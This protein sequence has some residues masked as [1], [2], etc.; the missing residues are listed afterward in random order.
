MIKADTIARI[1]DLGLLAVLRG[2]SPEL[3][4]QM[5][6]ASIRGGV[7]GIEITYTTPHAA[8][9]VA[10][11]AQRYGDGI[12]LGMGTLTTPAQADEAAAAGARFLVSPHVDVE[13]AAAVT[14]TGLPAM[15]G[16]LDA[17]RD[18]GR[19]QGRRRCGQ[20]L[21]R[22]DGRAG[23]P[24][25]PAGPFPDI[26]IMPTGGV[27]IDNVAD[28]FAAGALAVGVGSD[29]CPPAWAKA[30]RFDEITARARI[31]RRRGCGTHLAD[32]SGVNEPMVV[33]PATSRTSLVDQTV[34]LVA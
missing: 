30:G 23:L 5:V 1:A 7:T 10:A 18:D 26:P 14:A 11:L 9:V 24:Q 15:L 6:D 20:A 34:T 8:E 27:S 19:A 33:G 16:V 29:L 32:Q 17:D 4:M 22:V 2:P 28:W 25:G 12:V 31:C 21:S 13:L 3:T